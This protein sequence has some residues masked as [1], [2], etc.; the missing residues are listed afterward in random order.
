[1]KRQWGLSLLTLLA[2]TLTLLAETLKYG[3]L[4]E[5]DRGAL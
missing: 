2:E 4:F 1:M 3:D 5:R